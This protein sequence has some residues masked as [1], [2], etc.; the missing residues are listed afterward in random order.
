MKQLFSDTQQQAVYGG[1][2]SEAY[3]CPSSLLGDSVH[4]VVQRGGTQMKL[5]IPTTK[6]RQ[7]LEL[8]EAKVCRM[9]R[10]EYCRRESLTD[11]DSMLQKSEKLSLGCASMRGN[12]R[13]SVKETLENR[14]LKNS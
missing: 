9:Y 8:R 1:K 12:Y 3:N 13:R 14:R 5:S 11:S 4:A 10:M 2:R 6:W 7:R